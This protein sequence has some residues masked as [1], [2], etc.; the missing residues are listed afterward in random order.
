MSPNPYAQLFS[1]AGKTALVTGGSSGI[2]L[3]IAEAY[4][5][6]GARVYITGRK[7][8]AL[9]AARA[10]LAEFGEVRAVQGDVARAEGLAAIRTALAEEPGLHILVNNAGIT[11]GGPL[12]SFPA[13]AWDTVMATNVKAPF[14]LV[15]ALLPKLQAAAGPDDPAHVINIGSVYGELSQVLTAWSYGASKA[16]IH[17]LTKILAAELVGRG[18]LVNAIAPGFFPSKMT[19]FIVRDEQRRGEMLEQIPLGRSGTPEDI[20][21]LAIY[22]GSRA[23]AYMTGNVIPLDGGLLAKT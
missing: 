14:L 12:E 6:S 18:I 4:L 5:R 21:A 2:G 13:E 16:A 1:V 19:H 23:S 10:R 8:E 3:A 22:L 20:G 15:Q 7:A 9:E 17:H 11:W